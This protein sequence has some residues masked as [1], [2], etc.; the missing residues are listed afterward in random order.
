MLELKAQWAMSAIFETYNR[1]HNILEL[2]DIFLNV[3]F[4]TSEME[5]DFY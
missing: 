1:T 3:S 2:L 5:R 4:I